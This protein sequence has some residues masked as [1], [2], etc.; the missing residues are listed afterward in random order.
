M[1]T[2]QL[3][4]Y[5]IVTHQLPDSYWSSAHY[6]TISK[7]LFGT[8]LILFTELSIQSLTKQTLYVYVVPEYRI[9]HIDTL[10]KRLAPSR[11][12]EATWDIRKLLQLK[13]C[14]TI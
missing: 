4:S 14:G 8:D 9:V 12:L 1:F 11:C 13:S 6:V 2:Q 3:N 5:L 7:E 10:L